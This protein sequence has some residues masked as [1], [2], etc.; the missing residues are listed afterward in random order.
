MA[1]SLATVQADI[2]SL[3]AAMARGVLRV[4]HGETETTYAGPEQMLKAIDALLAEADA[5]ASRPI[6]QVRFQTSKGLDC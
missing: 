2:D 6:R 5:L 4:R 1:R 3:R